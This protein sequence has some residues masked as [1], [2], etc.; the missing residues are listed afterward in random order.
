MKPG[1]SRKKLEQTAARRKLSLRHNEPWKSERW[2][3]VEAYFDPNAIRPVRMAETADRMF[4]LGPISNIVMLHVPRE[5]PEKQI[6]DTL[7]EMEDQG[8]RVLAFTD[9]VQFVKL[10][11]CT[12][13]EETALNEREAKIV[14]DL[15]AAVARAAEPVPEPVAA[16]PEQ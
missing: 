3:A 1:Y 16:E 11:M 7:R 6:R 8:L 4:V 15:E 12:D 5:A 10:R 9:N 14:A 13:A 2:F